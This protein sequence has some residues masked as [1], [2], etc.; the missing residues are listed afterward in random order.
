MEFDITINERRGKRAV[1]TIKSIYGREVIT[2]LGD[3]DNIEELAENLVNT[4]GLTYSRMDWA[5]ITGR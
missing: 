3:D 1:L 4:Y 5:F 2:S